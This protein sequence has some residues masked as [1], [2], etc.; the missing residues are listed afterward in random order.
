MR[1]FWTFAGKLGATGIWLLTA[2]GPRPAGASVPPPT[3]DRVNLPHFIYQ[4]KAATSEIQVDGQLDEMAWQNATVVDLSYETQPGENIQAPVAT[5]ALITYDAN[6]FYI[7]FKA[8]DPDPRAIRAR[9]Q[10]RDTA[11]GDDL[12]GVIL[13]PF[14]DER[15][16][17]EFFVNPLGVQMDIFQDDI[18][19]NEDS[20][21]DAV[22][23]SAGR[24]TE[25]GYVV[26][27]AIPF[28]S[29]RFPRGS[30]E[31]TWGFDAL[32]FYPRDKRHRLASQPRDRN[33]SC[34][35]CQVSKMVGFGAVDPGHNLEVVPTAVTSRTDER[36]LE[37][38]TPLENGPTETE[39]GATVRWG[40]TPNVSANVTYN[41][42]FSQVE[43]DAAQ[44]NVNEQFA[45][46]FPEKRPF[47]LEG[48]DFFSTR[49][50]A[51]FTRNI[52][53][54]DWGLKLTG[55]AG[56]HGFGVF[57]AGDAKTNLLIPGAE[58]SDTT[59]LE[60]KSTDSVLRYRRDL[61]KGSTV[62]VLLTDRR[63][64]DY[65]NTVA[66][67]DSLL[68]LSDTDIVR[69]QLLGSKSRYP[70]SVVTDFDQP[71]GSFDDWAGII[72]YHKSSRD[73][74]VY[75]RIERYGENFRADLGFLPQ[76]GYQNVLA[77]ARKRW[78]N[79]AGGK[80]TQINFGGDWSQREKTTDRSLLERD[81]EIWTEI[82]GPYQSFAIF[83]GG[84]RTTGLEGH[85]FDQNR[86]YL[87]F[88]ATPSRNL[89]VSL[90]AGGGDAVDFANV[91]KGRNLRL[92]PAFTYR[93]GRHLQTTLTHTLRRIDV[94]GGRLF[95]ANLSDLRL[96]YQFNRRCFVRA[97][98]QYTDIVRDPKLYVD[99]VDQ[100][101]QGL[102]SQL[103]FSYKLNP[104]TVLFLGY[105]D[106]WEGDERID[107]ER[108]S[109]TLFLKL[110]YAW[111]L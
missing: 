78:Y 95:T 108:T 16:G 94:E 48:A 60:Q 106:L 107:L 44:L 4:V 45:L 93:M 109:R 76:V 104:Q 23:D 36:E 42:D 100:K 105:S 92:N 30:A 89:N 8:S 80:I 41:P 96:V 47:F 18:S 38:A 79:L 62:G 50:Q 33:I 83:G 98:L 15:R 55:K 101:T 2:L 12:V 3:D 51:V 39:L 35:L 102:F 73:W 57:V 74:E 91:R 13:D 14:N 88:E 87:Y 82:Q 22:W 11:W 31:Q 77:G 17:F 19:G 1:S 25:G 28:S 20:S 29:L 67:F 111:A 54:P 72:G 46:F 66:G 68:R 5:Q 59:T 64:A 6:R 58:S 24:L 61:G 43:A 70:G 69:A 75:G 7:A 32:R 90:D 34:H 110:G 86:A 81:L 56:Q 97:V 26:E 99:E 52:A 85:L 71:N 9:Y 65:Q 27:I 10:D 37:D 53:D 103:L 63:G 21:W 40:I 84:T 49:I